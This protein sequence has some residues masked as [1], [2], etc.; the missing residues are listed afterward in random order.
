L[1][2]DLLHAISAGG[3]SIKPIHTNSSRTYS[4]WIITYWDSA[5]KVRLAQGAWVRAEKNL[6]ELSRKWAAKGKKE[7]ADIVDQIFNVLGVLQWGHDLRG[8]SSKVRICPRRKAMAGAKRFL[9]SS[10]QTSS[11]MMTTKIQISNCRVPI[12]LKYLLYQVLNGPSTY[13]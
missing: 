5:F 10:L 3:H 7:S 11:T 1:K 2:K 12:L 13:L 6:C 9:T 8:F 4:L